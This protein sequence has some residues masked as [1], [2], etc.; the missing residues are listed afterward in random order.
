MTFLA[1]THI[2][3][4]RILV[5]FA[6]F[7]TSIQAAP[8]S[9]ESLNTLITQTGIQQNLDLAG[10]NL[11]TRLQ[12]H[13]N[14]LPQQLAQ[15]GSP[16]LTPAQKSALDKATPQIAQA[17]RNEL[18]WSQWQPMVFKTYQDALSQEEVN[19]LLALYKTPG[20]SALAQKMHNVNNATDQLI[21]QRLPQIIQKTLPMIEK[22]V[23]K[24]D[25]SAAP[26]KP[27]ANAP[28][29]PIYSRP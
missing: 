9:V 6:I 13:I 29:T 23:G 7:P 24:A 1:F 16:P 5:A 3:L 15:Q 26:I 17:I 4:L 2:P 19:Q 11:E 10:K 8:A 22:A 21:L 20:Y 27:P 28:S 14:Q 18:S 12:Q 25:T